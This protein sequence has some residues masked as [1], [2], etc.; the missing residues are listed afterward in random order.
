MI[1]F[2]SVCKYYVS[3]SE[4]VKAVDNISF[5]LEE[6]GYLAISGPS[7]SGK[8]TVLSML[9]VLNR[10]TRG[11]V[12]IDD[13]DVYNLVSEQ[14]AD[15]RSD[16]IGFVFQAFQMIPYLTALEN[17]MLPLAITEA[18]NKEQTERALEMLEKV[19]L[20]HKADKLPNQL[21]GGEIQRV[22]IARALIN[23]PPVLLADE[24]TGNLDSKNADS[25]MQL[26]KELNQSGQTV[27]IVTHEK[28]IAANARAHIEL[29]D[30][31]IVESRK[32]VLK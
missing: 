27:I 14:R 20:S 28:N 17:V 25:V 15:F 7:G 13:I 23:Q 10:P 21:S 16:Y 30:G 22:A 26:L 19:G 3:G 1:K 24:P 29:F 6:G 11:K 8:S 18:K 4:T 2:D 9:G 5:C 32:G 31:K 12:F